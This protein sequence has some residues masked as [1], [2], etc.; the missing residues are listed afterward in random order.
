MFY[1]GC[2]LEEIKAYDVLKYYF[3]GNAYSD[4]ISITRYY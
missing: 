3:D 4:K 1:E 2:T